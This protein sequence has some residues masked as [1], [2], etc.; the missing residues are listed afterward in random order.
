MEAQDVAAQP[1][2]VRR[3]GQSVAPKVVGNAP[4]NPRAWKR[5]GVVVAVGMLFG[6]AAS[7]WFG[8]PNPS[9]Q[10]AQPDNSTSQQTLVIIPTESVPVKQTAD[11]SAELERL[12]TRNRRLEALVQVLQKRAQA[13]K[14]GAALKMK[15]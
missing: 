2:V 1:V 10:K 6:F 4:K 7:L 13:G 14:H 8:S 3:M 5:A 11:N 9:T 12:K 15:N